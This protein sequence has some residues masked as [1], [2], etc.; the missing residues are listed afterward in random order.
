MNIYNSSSPLVNIIYK[1]PPNQPINMEIKCLLFIS[2]TQMFMCANSIQTF[3]KIQPKIQ[4]MQFKTHKPIMMRNM[5]TPWKTTL[6]VRSNQQKNKNHRIMHQT[7]TR[8]DS[9]NQDEN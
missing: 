7:L 2:H 1:R 6:K 4:L 9:F 8:T 5:N 3:L